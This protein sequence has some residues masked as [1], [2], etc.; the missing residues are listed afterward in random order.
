M[1]ITV[2]HKGTKMETKEI[3]LLD[4]VFSISAPYAAGHV[5]LEAEAK[6][7]NQTRAENIGN[8]FR[9]KVKAALDGIPLKEGGPIPT[10]ADITAEIAAYDATYNCSM[11]S[12]G[13]EPID[14]VE[15]E[16]KKIATQIVSEKIRA[17][18][19]KIKDV[20][21]DKFDGAVAKIMEREDVQA[22]AKRRVKAQKKAVT[23]SLDELDL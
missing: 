12:A 8:N 5:L 4:Q 18:G 22:E 17:S 11:P 2:I 9:K 16:A 1:P 3:S 20:D 10:L 23:E 13:R 6:A 15:R 7:L 14:P 19:R 21:E